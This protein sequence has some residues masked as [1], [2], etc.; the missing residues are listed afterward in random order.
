MCVIG[1]ASFGRFG[2]FGRFSHQVTQTFERSDSHFASG[3]LSLSLIS[4]SHTYQS[5]RR[6][7]QASSSRGQ[8]VATG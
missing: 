5:R 3:N 8:Q 1:V 6:N 2:R 7:R 4:V